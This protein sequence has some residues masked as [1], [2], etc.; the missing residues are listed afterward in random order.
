[1]FSYC[2]S[3]HFVFHR[4]KPQSIKINMCTTK[5][6]YAILNLKL[7]M[8]NYYIWYFYSVPMRKLLNN[9]NRLKA[10]DILLGKMLRI[11][12]VGRQKWSTEESKNITGNTSVKFVSQLKY[13][14]ITS[15]E[16]V[17]ITFCSY[18]L[19]KKWRITETEQ[20][21][22]EHN[23]YFIWSKTKTIL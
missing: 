11:S 2:L 10:F 5:F 22:K 20:A 9:K 14:Y 18:L 12:W 16:I 17:D 6:D 1:M 23:I 15:S 3:G 21:Y 7:R 19:K 13:I 4:S 8:D